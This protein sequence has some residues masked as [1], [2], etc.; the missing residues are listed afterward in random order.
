MLC[1]S[2]ESSGTSSFMS[3]YVAH[4]RMP[5]SLASRSTSGAVKTLHRHDFLRRRVSVRRRPRG[6]VQHVEPDGSL[7]DVRLDVERVPFPAPLHE[8]LD[9]RASRQ[10]AHTAD[11]SQRVTLRVHELALEEIVRVFELEH[12]ERRPARARRGSP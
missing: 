8:H 4:T 3:P 11:R 7:D 1:A 6:Y 10:F 2:S 9:P 12:G 5:A